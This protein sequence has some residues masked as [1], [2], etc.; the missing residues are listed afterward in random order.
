LNRKEFLNTLWFKSGSRVRK[1]QRIKS[2]NL[3]LLVHKAAR[4]SKNEILTP[5]P[6]P[7]AW[8][9]R[10]MAYILGVLQK[11]DSKGYVEDKRLFQWLPKR[12][13]AARLPH[14]KQNIPNTFITAKVNAVQGKYW[15]KDAGDA[16]GSGCSQGIRRRG[17][18]ERT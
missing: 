16:T 13:A 8:A 1:R 4:E 10:E 5:H 11:I 18:D 3:A 12:K 7:F 15:R 2:L 17:R 6:Y 9:L 14:S